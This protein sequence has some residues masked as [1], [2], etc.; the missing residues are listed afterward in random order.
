[1]AQTQD[2][3]IGRP[4]PLLLKFTLPLLLGQMLQQTYNLIDA[5]VVGR[6][7]G[8]HS[9]AAIG[10]SSSVLFLIIGF[11]IGTA[12]GFA[13]PV[14]QAFGAKDIAAIRRYVKN[15]MCVTAFISVILA[16]VTC[17]M[18]GRILQWMST[19]AEIYDQAHTYLFITFAGIPLVFFYNLFACILRALG[20]SRTPLLMLILSTS[21][22][23]V[24]D[25][26]F[27]LG[28]KWGVAGAAF[29]T[30]I[31]QIISAIL[32]YR[33][34]MRDFKFLRSVEGE[35]PVK[36]STMLKLL[37]IGAPMGLQY[38]ITA[39]GSIMLQSS[40]NMLGTEY[41]AAFTTAMRIKMFFICAFD[42]LGMAMATF[43]GQNLGAGKIERVKKGV[44]TAL[45]MSGVYFCLCVFI[46]FTFPRQIVDLFVST[47]GGFVE[48]LAVQFLK[49]SCTFYPFLASLNI[50]RFTIQGLGF[51]NFAMI[52]GVM[53][54]IARILISLL[55]VPVFK[56]TGVCFGDPV[57]WIAANIFL[58]PAFIYVYHRVSPAK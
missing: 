52:S 43:A 10:A 27:I 54:M 51:T 39:I 19:P 3:T 56:F 36:V 41:A 25:L 53:E 34:M 17:Y 7:L 58:I 30:M 40:N 48:N 57:A 37:A 8:I 32:C 44:L 13:I 9:L 49:I 21:L 45:G 12:G 31:A 18:C 29:A 22:N 11:C 15:S 46:L 4:L 47:D 23:I 26:L 1:M 24:L 2:L 35:K 42:S 20:D 38:S 33:I 5:A 55:I 50:I 16:A 14:A 28:F 6:F